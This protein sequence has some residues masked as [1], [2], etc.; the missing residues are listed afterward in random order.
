MASKSD[1]PLDDLMMAMDVVDTLRHEEGQVAR[2]L[3]TDERDAAMVERLRQVYASQG[4]DVPDHILKAGVEDLKRDRFV[5]SPPSAGF[6]RT[7]AMIYISRSTWSKWLAAVV[8]VVIVCIAAWYFI[9]KLPAQRAEADLLARLQALPATYTELVG[10]IDSLTE[11]TE[12]EANAARLA[13]DGNLAL[14][15]GNNEAAFKAE[16]DLRDLAGRLQEVFE[17]RIISREG[18]PTGVSRIPESNPDTENYYIVVEAVDADGKILERRI[19][20]EESSEAELVDKWGQRVSET[21]YNAVRRDKME[22]GIVQKGVLGQKRRGEL[23]IKWRS[24]VQD[25]AITKW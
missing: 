14:S 9:V 15:D 11:N 10:R 4:I 19:V 12:I 22:D 8:A 17:V 6:Q 5:Y 13:T 16:A 24:G 1:A 3:K 7:L 21:I 25:G 2:E 18:V 23:D 20:S